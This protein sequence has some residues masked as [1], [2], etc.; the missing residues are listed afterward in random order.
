MEA[1]PSPIITKS[2]RITE[3]IHHIDIQA[4]AVKKLIST[5]VL[6]TPEAVAIIDTGT[7][8]DVYKLLRF[9]KKLGI[10]KEK[11]KY[12]V[13]SHYH[14]D[15]FGGG[16]RLW[17]M[18]KP[19]NPAVKVLTTQKTHDRL[20]DTA[21]HMQHAK[22]TF[23]EF[24]GEMRPL[25]EEAFEIVEPDTPLPIPGLGGGKTFQLVSTPGHTADHCS[26][27]L[28]EKDGHAAFVYCAEAAGTLF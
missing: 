13:P 25:P 11:I 22:R 28:L 8:D 2:G 12:L 15:H 20:Q 1:P 24:I 3:E 6:E 27:A 18:L 9:L 26:P 7:S 16:W 21:V 5:F 4:Y 23:G 17:E 14:F 10:S 19:E